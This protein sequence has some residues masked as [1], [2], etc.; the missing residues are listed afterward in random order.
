MSTSV[1]GVWLGPDEDGVVVS[2]ELPARE[3]ARAAVRALGLEAAP[4]DPR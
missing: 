4:A 3:C 2:I 1:F